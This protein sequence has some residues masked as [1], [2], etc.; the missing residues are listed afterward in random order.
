MK[1]LVDCH[2]MEPRIRTSFLALV[3]GLW[4][5]E[6]FA[7]VI[8]IFFGH[9]RALVFAFISKGTFKGFEWGRLIP[10]FGNPPLPDIGALAWEPLQALEN[11]QEIFCYVGMSARWVLRNEGSE[12][13]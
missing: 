1:A 5:V 4:F 13:A 7:P 10:E 9:S 11:A 8:L 12:S 2:S 6:E 3:S